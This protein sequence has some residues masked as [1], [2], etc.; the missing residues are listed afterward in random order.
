MNKVNPINE[1][2][3]GNYY[4][5]AQT[6]CDMHHV[7]DIIEGIRPMILKPEEQQKTTDRLDSYLGENL[8]NEK[9]FALVVQLRKQI[10]Q[11]FQEKYKQEILEVYQSGK[12]EGWQRW[13]EIFGRELSLLDN[14]TCKF[15]L[16]TD[17]PAKEHTDYPYLKKHLLYV[18]EERWVEGYPL[19][20]YFIK[21]EHLSTKTRAG[22]HR[23][24]GLIQLYHL[25]NYST[26]LEHFKE[27]KKLLPDSAQ[28]ERVFGQYYIQ[29][30]DFDKARTRVQKALDLDRKDYENYLVL[31][32]LFKAENRF[33]TAASWY[34]EGIRVNPGKADLYNRLLLLNENPGYFKQHSGEIDQLLKT[35]VR[36]DP[37]FEYTA[38]NNAAFVH[39]KNDNFEEAESFYRQSIQRYPE[40]IQAYTNLGYAYLEM[41]ELE[42]SEQ[43]FLKTIELDP[44]TL[45]GYWGMVSLN[46]KKGDWK[47]VIKNL[48][49]GR[50]L[51]T[52]WLPFIYNEFGNAYE[53]LKDIANAQKY[54][55][56]ALENDPEKEL[57]LTALYD[58]A[59]SSPE[60]DSGISLL[61]KVKQHVKPGSTGEVDY[62]IGI[63]LYNNFQ[64]DKAI[65]YF[66]KA[67]ETK[68]GNPE[69]LEYLGLSYQNS[70]DN[71]NAE[72]SFRKAIK[73]A[74]TEKDTYYNRL[75]FFLTGLGRYS[76]AMELLQKA[77]EIKA[78][79]LYYENVGYAQELSG[80]TDKALASYLKALEL[81]DTDK[82]IYENRLG[83]FYY[84]LQKY[85][86]SV[87]HYTNA[88]QLQPK[89]VYFEN[90]G[91][92]CENSGQFEK[93]KE[94][95]RNALNHAEKN[96][97]VYYNRLGY[98]L[99]SRGEYAEAVDLL[100]KAIET[101]PTPVYHENL[102]YAFENL[103]K[104]D[105]AEENYKKALQLSAGD[106]DVYYNRLGIFFYNQKNYDEALK[107]YLKATGEIKKA[108]YYENLGNLYNEMGNRKLFEEAMNEAA[109][110]EPWNGRYYF[111]LGWNILQVYN[112]TEKAKVYLNKALD[113]FRDTP[114]IEPEE[115]M[116]MQFLGAA[117]Q[118]EGN[119]DKAE[120][121]FLE[122]Y[123]LD[124]ENELACSFL[125]RT[126]LDKNEVEKALIYYEKALD[127]N[128]KKPLNYKNA[129]DVLART[130]DT[131]KALKTY[132]K[133]AELDP[134]IYESVAK[135]Y[136]NRKDFASA[137]KY[138][139]KALDAFPQNYIYLENLGLTLQNRKQLAEARET[140]QKAMEYAPV[141]DSPI[142]LNYI[143]NTWYAENNFE[144]SAEYYEKAYTTDPQG[145]FYF[146]NLILALKSGKNEKK[147]IELLEKKM[148]AEPGN[149][150]AFNSLGLMYF[151][152]KKYTE[153]ADC[154]RQYV[155][156]FPDDPLGYNNLGYTYE[157]MNEPEKA[158]E[159]YNSGASYDNGLHEKTGRIYF[160][161]QDYPAAEKAIRMAL[162]KTSGNSDYLSFLALA[163]V[164]QN[165][166][167]EAAKIYGQAIAIQPQNAAYYS[168]LGEVREM[169]GKPDEAIEC[170][171]KAIENE[172]INKDL[173][174]Y[175]LGKLYQKLPD[176]EKA[177]QN[178][179]AALEIKPET[180]YFDELGNLLLS[181]KDFDQAAEMYLKALKKAPADTVFLENF[182]KSFQ[183]ISDKQKKKNY[184][185]QAAGI[186]GLNHERLNSQ[187]TDLV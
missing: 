70:G 92:A 130:G 39:Q 40:R 80:Q 114:E 91:L 36:L 35:I 175:Q 69:L 118:K 147:A 109:R 126:Y 98:F 19:F 52:G 183:G 186:A 43:S 121:V 16:E 146:Q 150:E 94:S 129:G 152:L 42:K 81:A 27:A 73:A 99:T 34:G 140:F 153:A 104:A 161:R 57:G 3:A 76:E 95:Y 47:A 145:R 171:Q 154:F 72:T 55:L 67:S 13:L 164:R 90:L 157:M 53:K 180:A 184:Y 135:I 50:T 17:L 78:R 97:D 101:N 87:E 21:T 2:L 178:F 138:I 176:V 106:K 155:Q 71:D 82:D 173:Y 123:R 33:D 128:P 167:D 165:K 83:V 179:E 162:A 113:I 75:A 74:T 134:S 105:E 115:L 10:K 160:D 14:D 63:I 46:R 8:E 37:D 148:A 181:E 28:S 4:R 44:E 174:Y 139:R 5:A 122:A 58:L 119:P 84:N 18:A 159:T 131:E 133:G 15:L 22:L 156:K 62:R 149:K 1:L 177:R 144:K 23:L 170:L 68:A 100:K 141:A 9:I 12:K 61:E 142:Y 127:L 137:E 120:E 20:E 185:E 143:G 96:K 111:H 136:F 66:E 51:R 112:D 60:T 108:V 30:Q 166:I 158:I 54:Y 56:L 85:K 65:R 187:M 124:P 110:L 132:I 38:L 169:Q 182:S 48:E 11:H 103:G 6:G 26:A 7:T 29:K 151:D 86:K 25:V 168:Q 59:D 41:N 93:A 172:K 102:G 163:L 49:T 77:I 88:I 117:Y 31:G 107:Y 24:A 125:G 45:D 32:D 64:Y 79:P 116:S 89:P